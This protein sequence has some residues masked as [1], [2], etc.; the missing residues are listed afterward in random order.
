MKT[1]LSVLMPVLGDAA[2]M[3]VDELRRQVHEV[4]ACIDD[5]LADEVEYL[6]FEHDDLNAQR[7]AVQVVDLLEL[8]AERPLDGS[9]AWATSL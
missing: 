7:L 5:S 9:R 3:A 6:I 8:D 2:P 4:A 1:A